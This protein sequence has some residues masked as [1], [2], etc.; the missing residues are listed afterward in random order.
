VTVSFKIHELATCNNRLKQASQTF[1]GTHPPVT[2]ALIFYCSL[3]GHKDQTCSEQIFEVHTQ[4]Q[5]CN[6]LR[7]ERFRFFHF[8]IFYCCVSKLEECIELA[9]NKT[10]EIFTLI[11]K[12][13]EPS[14]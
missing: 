7:S 1:L 5:G 6:P 11:C 2:F 13:T 4:K 12:K 9:S 8:N 3:H 14:S 10:E